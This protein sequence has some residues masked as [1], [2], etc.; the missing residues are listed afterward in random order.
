MAWP[1]LKAKAV[2]MAAAH[3]VAMAV[4]KVW[5]DAACRRLTRRFC[6]MLIYRLSLMQPDQFL[7]KPL[8]P[9]DLNP[10][11]VTLCEFC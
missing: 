4:R 10:F 8:K 9:V 11:Y 1:W 6:R 7:T 2:T 3:V 5:R